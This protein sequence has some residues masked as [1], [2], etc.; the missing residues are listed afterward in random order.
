MAFKT[1]SKRQNGTFDPGLFSL[2]LIEGWVIHDW[3][4]FIS[5]G[6]NIIRFLGGYIAKHIRQ[7]SSL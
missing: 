1:L 5:S 3:K 7:N 6:E 4:T 2:H